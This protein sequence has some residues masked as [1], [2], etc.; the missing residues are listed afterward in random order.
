[1]RRT[2][3]VVGAGIA[4][5]AAARALSQA[6][7]RAIVLER[8]AAPT[9]EGA[10][11]QL[12]PNACHVLSAL[13]ALRTVAT[14]AFAPH[15]ARLRRARDG[16]TLSTFQFGETI[17]ERHGAPYLVVERAILRN[18]L[19][20]VCEAD[21]DVDVRFGEG[22]SDTAV[23]SNGTTVLT[24]RGR[25][26]V[27]SGLVGADGVH[28]T[29]RSLVPGA[30]A[31]ETSGWTAWRAT[32]PLGVR[33]HEVC[34]WLGASAHLVHY[35]MPLAERLNM[36]LVA[37]DGVEPHEDERLVGWS[38]ETRRLVNEGEGWAPWSIRTVPAESEW[39]HRSIVL[40]GDA[41]HAMPPYAAQGAAMALEDAI[42]L[43]HAAQAVQ[44]DLPQA[45]SSY[46]QFRRPRIDNVRRVTLQNRRIYHMRRP[47]SLARDLTMRLAPQVVLQRRM[48]PIYGWTLDRSR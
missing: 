48:D 17:R 9:S 1:M 7:F 14:A 26:I 2:V 24:D 28:S 8:E 41:A 5:L 43:A 36:V 39:R 38:D 6:G 46:E 10:G 3:I 35:P 21:R 12:S 19:L 34:A 32:A 45:W 23:H 44:D 4:G 29:V 47:A 25:E 18:A 30:L 37:R 33:A 40:I 11:L 22:L 31:A 20:G 27:A 15:A 42:S 13:G 16:R